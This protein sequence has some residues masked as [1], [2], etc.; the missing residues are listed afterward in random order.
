MVEIKHSR[1][2]ALYVTRQS[3]FTVSVSLHHCEQIPVRNNGGNEDVFSELLSIMS[4]K[5]W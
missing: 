1:N 5:A 4:R 2:N 3:E